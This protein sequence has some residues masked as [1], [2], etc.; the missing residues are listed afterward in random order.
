MRDMKLGLLSDT[1]QNIEDLRVAI[2]HLVRE[3]VDCLV[4][5]GDDFQDAETF[6][7]FEIKTTIAVPGVYDPEYSDR[8][9]PHRLIE[10]VGGFRVMFSHTLESHPNDFPD[11]P[12]PEDF[13][14]KGEIDILLYGHTHVPRIEIKDSILLVNPGHLRKHDKRGHRATFGL[15]EIAGDEARASVFDFGKGETIASMKFRKS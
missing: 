4:H 3:E 9:V 1:H 5:L 13:L 7:E 11:D 8:N 14:T 10:D 12:K 2:D 15:L 6:D